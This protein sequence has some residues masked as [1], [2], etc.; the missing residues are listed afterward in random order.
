MLDGQYFQAV[1]DDGKPVDAGT[2]AKPDV[3]HVLMSR[4][5]TAG[6]VSFFGDLHP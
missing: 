5:R 1:D 4:A 2:L 6:F 3:A